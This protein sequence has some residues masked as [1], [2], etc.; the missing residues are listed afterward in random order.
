MKNCPFYG[1][2]LTIVIGPREDPPFRLLNTHG[3]QCGLVCTAHSPC[4]LEI[5]GKPVE[6]SECPR[7][8]E[9]RL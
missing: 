1:R 8:A 2:Y 3:N 9:V 4:A 6:W 7:I 5:E